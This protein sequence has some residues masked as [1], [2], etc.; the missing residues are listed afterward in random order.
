MMKNLCILFFLF[1]IPQLCLA[2]DPVCGLTNIRCG[3]SVN[4]FSDLD[5]AAECNFKP[6]FG[7]CT[8]EMFGE[9]LPKMEDLHLLN[10]DDLPSFF[11]DTED[12]GGNSCNGIIMPFTEECIT[13]SQMTG[14]LDF[15]MKIYLQWDMSTVDNFIDLDWRGKISKWAFHTAGENYKSF[16]ELPQLDPG[17]ELLAER[18]EELSVSFPYL[19]SGNT[20][21]MPQIP[22]HNSFKSIAFKMN[23]DNSIDMR[24]VYFD[25]ICVFRQVGSNK[26]GGVEQEYISVLSYDEY[27][28][29][30]DDRMFSKVCMMTLVDRELDGDQQFTG[31]ILKRSIPMIWEQTVLPAH[32]DEFTMNR[33]SH[34]TGEEVNLTTNITKINRANL[35]AVTKVRNSDN[36]VIEEGKKDYTGWEEAEKSISISFDKPGEYMV[37]TC[38]EGDAGGMC[39]NKKLI[40][41]GDE[42]IAPP[43]NS[44]LTNTNTTSKPSISN[45]IE[46]YQIWDT[47]FPQIGIAGLHYFK[48]KPKVEKKSIEWVWGNPNGEIV[49]Y[50]YETVEQSFDLLLTGIHSIGLCITTLDDKYVCNTLNIDVEYRVI[51]PSGKIPRTFNVGGMNTFGSLYTGGPYTYTEIPDLGYVFVATG[52]SW[53]CWGFLACLIDDPQPGTDG[54]D[55]YIDGD[56]LTFD[57]SEEWNAFDDDDVVPLTRD[58]YVERFYLGAVP[59]GY[60]GKFNGKHSKESFY[61]GNSG[62]GPQAKST[63]PFLNIV[64]L[65]RDGVELGVKGNNLNKGVPLV[66]GGGVD[67][68]NVMLLTFLSPGAYTY[69]VTL[70]DENRTNEVRGKLLVNVDVL[71]NIP[72]IKHIES[73]AGHNSSIETFEITL[74]LPNALPLKDVWLEFSDNTYHDL[75][76]WVLGD[77]IVRNDN[78]L[79][80][81]FLVDHAHKTSGN[82]SAKICTRD[83]LL[84]EICKD[85]FIN[86]PDV[87][88]FQLSLPE[89]NSDFLISGSEIKFG[90]TGSTSDNISSIYIDYGDGTSETITNGFLGNFAKIFSHAYS[91]D[92][93]YTVKVCAEDA[94]H[95]VSCK[96]MEIEI[97]KPPLTHLF[98]QVLGMHSPA[99]NN[100]LMNQVLQNNIAIN[101]SMMNQV[102]QNNIAI[103]NSL[104]NQVMMPSI[105]IQPHVMQNIVIP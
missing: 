13:L 104:I 59:V 103:N 72:D 2:Q 77:N 102:L 61:R 20:F 62:E 87:S 37:T 83:N 7:G 76:Y 94:T 25:K 39:V 57:F 3:L 43:I 96:T 69:E 58:N 93:T 24:N 54:W 23:I 98:S 60:F 100:S 80:T 99:I 11:S 56:V 9:Y 105:A 52:Y 41:G 101:N 8:Y 29:S 63:D 30:S 88:T 53:K 75:S 22:M 4:V 16:M 17:L 55:Y 46:L 35:V 86:R 95:L 32:I 40:I 84:T 21:I 82:Y 92:G 50:P 36:E 97:V 28:L 81:T 33:N 65:A 64:P 14:T 19:Y 68:E 5:V 45:G 74:D 27:Y 66:D 48:G 47:D 18:L 89:Q 78:S 42:I 49:K 26:F 34:N 51:I 31:R 10:F 6:E 12:E 91:K 15:N 73:R 1:L 38:L 79:G 44:P 90:L 71:A 70:R 85:I 67:L